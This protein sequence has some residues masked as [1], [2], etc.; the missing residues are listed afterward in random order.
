MRTAVRVVLQTLDD[1]WNPILLPLEVDD[2]VVLLMTT[3]LMTNR[4]SA[5]IVTT[6]VAGLFLNQ[7]VVR[8][9]LVQVR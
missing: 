6:A 8:G 2:P 3:T 7:R 4:D 9:T 5:F 1:S